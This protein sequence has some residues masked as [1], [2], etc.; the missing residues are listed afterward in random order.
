[1]FYRAL[2]VFA[3]LCS[4]F[5]AFA[6]DPLPCEVTPDATSCSRIF[7]CIGQSGLWFQGR[8]I[9]RGEGDL[10]GRL[11]DGTACTGTWTNANALGQPQADF[12]CE[13]NTKGTVYY[14]HQD[15]YSGT[16][17]GRGLTEDGQSVE[18]WSGE[19]VTDFFRRNSPTS[20]ALMH[21]GDKDIPV[22]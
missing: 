3:L 4:T 1:M 13:N 6:G 21:C 18:V 11:S 10:D 8:A 20:E 19:H 16:A 22:S 17:L 2:P 12:S 7:A 15:E 9:G 5:P 14:Y